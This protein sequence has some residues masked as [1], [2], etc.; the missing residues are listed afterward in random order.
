MLSA[1]RC[2]DWPDARPWQAAVRRSSVA[3]RESSR[4]VSNDENQRSTTSFLFA[5]T[6]GD[7]LMRRD[8]EFGAPWVEVTDATNITAM[9]IYAN[10]IWVTDDRLWASCSA[11][12]G[13]ER[14]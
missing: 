10:H 1:I 3:G 12:G 4:I 14:G 5:A 8:T 11:R 7:Q 13:G 2:D 6:T 9:A